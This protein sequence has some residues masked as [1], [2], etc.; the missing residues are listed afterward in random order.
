MLPATVSLG[1]T[2][3]CVLD[4]DWVAAGEGQWGHGR[5][6]LGLCITLEKGREEDAKGS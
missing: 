3:E 5:R 1:K 2:G 4:W 6:G